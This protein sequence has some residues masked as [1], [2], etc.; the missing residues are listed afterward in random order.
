[1]KTIIYMGFELPDGNASSLRVFYN[2]LALKEY[3]IRVVLLD[4]THNEGLLSKGKDKL[5]GMDIWYIPAPCSAMSWA[6]YLVDI[7]PYKEIFTRQDAIEAI[8]TYDQPGISFFRLRNYCRKHS[9]KLI[10]DCAERHSTVHLRGVKR[11]V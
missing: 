7:N 6:K 1:M 4:Y 5:A 10:C 8:I 3:G 11:I 9:I 2:A